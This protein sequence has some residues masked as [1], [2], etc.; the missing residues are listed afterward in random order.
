MKN[1]QFVP[2]TLEVKQYTD[3]S[4]QDDLYSV[5]HKTIAQLIEDKYE[6]QENPV[7]SG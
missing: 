3:L 2:S 1:D 5:Q 6:E 7:T 4:I